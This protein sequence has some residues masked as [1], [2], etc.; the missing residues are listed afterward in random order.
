MNCNI[1]FVTYILY[2]HT[3]AL[4][5]RGLQI[6][7]THGTIE[8]CETSQYC[9]RGPTAPSATSCPKLYVCTRSPHTDVC[10]SWINHKPA[11]LGWLVG[12]EFNAPFYTVVMSEAVFTAN[13]L[14]GKQNSTWKKQ[15]TNSIQ[16]RKSRQPKI[17]QNKTTLIQLPLTT[18]GQETRWA[19]STTLPSPHGA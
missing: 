11:K 1:H 18:L 15:K 14:T 17:Q 3:L 12:V 9:H 6:V 8:E 7:S 2:I 16:I 4:L 19:Y 13:H 5:T 10:W